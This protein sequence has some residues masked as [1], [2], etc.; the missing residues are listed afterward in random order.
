MRTTLYL[1]V[2]TLAASFVRADIV[3]QRVEYTQGDVALVG[4]LCY[5]DATT[6]PRPGVLVVPEWW[7]NNAYARSRAH[8]LAE[9]GYV[10]FAADMYGD[11]KTTDDGEQA[12]AWAMPFYESP[13]KFSTRAQA[14][15][16]VLAAHPLTDDQPLAAIGFCFGGSTVMHLA[17]TNTDR[18]AG[19]VSFHGS[20]ITIPEDAPAPIEPAVLICHGSDDPFYTREQLQATIDGFKAHQAEVTLIEYEGARHSFTNPAA[21]G[22]FSPGAIY[23]EAAATESWQDMQDFFDIVFAGE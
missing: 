6:D 9:L 19:V 8:Q 23:N 22:S 17:A 5:D 12:K 21:D 18:L 10:A 14:G 7:G 1:I 15:L 2:L 13:A 20:P 4:Y 16:D 3:E 11:G